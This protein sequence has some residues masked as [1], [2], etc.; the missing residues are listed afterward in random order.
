VAGLLAVSLVAAGIALRI[1]PDSRLWVAA[2]W[3]AIAGVAETAIQGFFYKIAPFLIWLHRYAPLAGRR[4][5]PRLED[6]YDRRLAL[7]G[8]A[9]WSLGL[10]L[11]L[12]AMLVAQPA[13]GHL[14]GIVVSVSLA[15]FLANA[16][17]IG[18]HGLPARAGWGGD[19]VAR[20]RTPGP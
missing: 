16:G 20:W 12:V 9:L 3:L 18:R 2:G 19:L 5:V 15:C 7:A 13:I 10:L 17:R 4:P 11:S 14:A 1:G 8:W 6:L